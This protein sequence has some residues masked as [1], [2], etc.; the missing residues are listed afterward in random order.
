MVVQVS[1]VDQS[2]VVRVGQQTDRSML[3]SLAEALENLG[4]VGGPMIVDLT[5]FEASLDAGSAA[6]EFVERFERIASL[7]PARP[8]AAV[9]GQASINRWPRLSTLHVFA[10]LDAAVA[11]CN[12]SA[13]PGGASSGAGPGTTSEPRQGRP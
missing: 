3:C 12:P 10:T 2:L 11:A 6:A 9:A 4:D 7:T 13:S 5:E 1:H 8:C